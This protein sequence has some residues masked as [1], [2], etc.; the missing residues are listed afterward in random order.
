MKDRD[1]Y[2]IDW[3]DHTGDSGWF[4]NDS[5]KKEKPITAR[6][7]GYLVEENDEYYKLVD[8]ITN[9]NG[10]GGLSIILKSCVQDIWQLEMK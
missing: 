4:D 1:I 7:I 3:L 9:D 8:T 2:I 6:T 5:V 10:V